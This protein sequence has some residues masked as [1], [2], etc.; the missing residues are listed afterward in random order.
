MADTAGRVLRLLSLLQAHRE[1]PGPE[2][3]GRLGVSAR[4]L[5]RD[6]GRLRDLGYP[7]HATTG[8]AGGYRLEAGTAMPPLL[9]DD[10]EAVAIAVGL[11]VAASGTVAGIEETSA[12]A[13]AKLEQVL[14]SR[15]R[16]RVHTLQSQTQPVTPVGGTPT[17][18]AGTLALLAQTCRDRER[19][20][21]GYR[22]RDGQEGGRI[23]EPYRLASTGRRWYLVAWDVDRQDWRTFRVD[24]L[25]SPRS[26]GVR[27]PPRE[28]PPGYVE[29]SIVAPISRH[30]AVV[31][32]HAPPATVAERY[33]GPGWVLQEL[34]ERS[35]LLRTGGDSL[36]WLALT[37]GLLGLDFTVHEPPELVGLI[38]ELAARLQ[39]STEPPLRQ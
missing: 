22:R 21:F 28:P 23:A 20:R 8:P 26:T 11:R 13:L 27:F 38:R 7:V 33:S 32:V 6:V 17:V 2:L 15:L 29:A 5:R 37:I 12:R 36:E 24:R 25:S 4:T 10:A 34:D 1:W 16:R 35:C 3:A 31:T 14:P 18:E 39:A 19:I 9:L 30:R